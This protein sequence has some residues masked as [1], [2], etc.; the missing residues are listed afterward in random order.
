MVCGLNVANIITSALLPVFKSPVRVSTPLIN[1]V[2]GSL[3]MLTEVDEDEVSTF[4]LNSAICVAFVLNS[5]Y[6]SLIM[7]SPC[8]STAIA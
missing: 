7:L 1:I 2:N 4:C 8:S 3:A 6:T 5:G